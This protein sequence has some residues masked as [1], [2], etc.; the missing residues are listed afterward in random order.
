M[1]LPEGPTDEDIDN[2]DMFVRANAETSYHS[3]STCRMGATQDTGECWIFRL[4]SM[5]DYHLCWCLCVI[6]NPHIQV[7]RFLGLIEVRADCILAALAR[8][9]IC[10][11]ASVSF[12]TCPWLEDIWFVPVSTVPRYSHLMIVHRKTTSGFQS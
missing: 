9:S 3:T 4:A 1:L 2:I 8:R 7:C 12:A 10:R 6:S 5:G 11:R